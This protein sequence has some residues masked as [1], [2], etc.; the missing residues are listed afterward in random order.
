MS[1]ASSPHNDKTVVRCPHADCEKEMR[2]PRGEVG[3]VKCPYCVRQFSAD[4]RVALGERGFATILRYPPDLDGIP[5][6][7]AAA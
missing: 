7:T 2:L 5:G 1:E 3:T 4:T 6:R